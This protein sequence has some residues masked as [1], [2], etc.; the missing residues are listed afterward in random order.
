LIADTVRG[1]A[2]GYAKILVGVDGSSASEE[3]TAVAAELAA[4]TNAELGAATVTSSEPVG[5]AILAPLRARW[6]HVTT[7][8]LRGTPTEALCDLAE[9]G[10]YD[11]LVVGNKGAV[12]ARRL[13]GS[14]A[15][16]IARRS[17]TNVLIVNAKA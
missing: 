8:V 7:A 17:P 14:V 10:G 2:P 3:V 15:D 4:A 16:K 1:R 13:R 11:L 6:P 12:G 5:Q 9:S